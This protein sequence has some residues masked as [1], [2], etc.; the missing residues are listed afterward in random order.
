MP[1]GCFFPDWFAAAT[2]TFVIFC[3]FCETFLVDTSTLLSVCFEEESSSVDLGLRLGLLTKGSK[4][5]SDDEVSVFR[6]LLLR[7]PEVLLDMV[8][9]VLLAVDGFCFGFAPRCLTEGLATSSASESD[10]GLSLYDE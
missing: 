10:G 7:A 5:A 1:F 8:F 4:S 2:S 6:L 9:F 3:F